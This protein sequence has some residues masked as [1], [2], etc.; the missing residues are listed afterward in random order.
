MCLLRT[1]IAVILKEMEKNDPEEEEIVVYRVESNNEKVDKN[2]DYN[3]TETIPSM[4]D[5]SCVIKF[6]SERPSQ[7]GIK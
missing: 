7:K 4:G 3:I 1:V 6:T 5:K 2:Y